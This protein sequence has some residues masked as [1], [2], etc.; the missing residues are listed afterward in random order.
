M[1]ARARSF[2]TAA[3]QSSGAIR[4]GAF[5]SIEQFQ[6]LLGSLGRAVQ[7]LRT[8][9]KKIGKLDEKRNVV[10]RNRQAALGGR[11]RLFPMTLR[12]PFPSYQFT[13]RQAQTGLREVALESSAIF[14]HRSVEHIQIGV[15][16]SR[17]FRLQVWKKLRV[18]W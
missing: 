7:P 9:R 3:V 17:S 8:I 10:R 2:A 15:I 14:E 6:R 1:C 5:S 12:P 18:A 4:S 13:N 16:F 11:D